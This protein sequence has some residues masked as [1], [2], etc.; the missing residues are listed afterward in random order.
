MVNISDISASSSTIA[1]TRSNCQKTL[2]DTVHTEQCELPTGKLPVQKVVVCCLLHLLRPDRAGKAIH[3]INESAVLLPNAL[4][5]HWHFCNVCTIGERH[6]V[7]K[8]CGVYNEFK[9]NCQTRT[10]RKTDK[11]KERM[12]TYNHQ[13]KSTLFDISIQERQLLRNLE[14]QYDMK[15][16][17]LEYDFLEEQKGPLI[18]YCTSFIDRKWEKTTQRRQKDQLFYER[19]KKNEARSRP[20]AITW[21][22]VPSNLQPGESTA[23]SEVDTEEAI[24]ERRGAYQ[25]V[26]VISHNP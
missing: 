20:E 14:E 18:G 4:V 22:E 25:T 21:K 5:E 15:M 23:T 9:K 17:S 1:T 8:I 11:W 2:H 10:D 19:M 16:T 7:K 26:M 24:Y 12:S 13:C 6:I 3:T